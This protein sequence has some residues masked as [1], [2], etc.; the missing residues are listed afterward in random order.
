MGAGG[1]SFPAPTDFGDFLRPLA[2]GPMD[3]F[4]ILKIVPFG[5]GEL[6]LAFTNSSL[7]MLISVASA[8]VFFVWAA[9]GRALVP[10]RGQS[11]AEMSYEF[12]GGMMRDILGDEGKPFF[13]FVF[14][15]FTFILLANLFGLLPSV[16]G[17]PHEFH[18][19][20]PTSHIV[21]TFALAMFSIGLVVIVGVAK[22]GIG[23]FKLFFPSGVPWPMYLLVTP[24]E[25]VS[26]LSRPISLSVRLFA[27]MFAGHM[28]LKVFGGFIAQ[29][30]AL[31]LLGGLGAIVTLGVASAMTVLE[32]LVAFL[33][34][35]VFAILTT[36][37]INDALHPAH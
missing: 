35:Y 26:F 32:I 4:E 31:G 23:F 5:F 15:L 12:I 16:P 27:N 24:I 25:I 3:Q 8:I 2:A 28:L 29:L 22:N 34:A 9:R 10:S 1:G 6:D 37:Y 14:T 17:A 7:W 11:V 13:P 21:V 19:F 36:I 33:Q 30:L 18:T 20:T